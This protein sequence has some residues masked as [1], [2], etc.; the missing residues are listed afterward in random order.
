MDAKQICQIW[1]CSKNSFLYAAFL[2]FFK[3]KSFLPDFHVEKFLLNS[4]HDAMPYYQYCK[5]TDI[6]PFIDLNE[7]YG[8]R[9]KY[10]E[11]FTLGK[12]GIPVCRAGI[13]MRHDGIE[14]SRFRIKFRS[15]LI[16][17]KYGCSCESLCSDSN[18]E[19]Q[20]IWL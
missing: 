12:D 11:Y 16:S 14:I 8:I 7:K 5:R 6:T 17:R 15:P 19:G 13:K 9:E 10:K 4:A 1:P 18:T 2:S 20:F 3:M